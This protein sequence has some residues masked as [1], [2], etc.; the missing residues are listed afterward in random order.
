MA[1]LKRLK[2]NSAG[3]MAEMSFI[4]HLEELRGHLFRSVIAIVLGGI[5]VLR[6]IGIGEDRGVLGGIDVESGAD[7]QPGDLHGALRDALV[8]L[9]GRR[10]EKISALK[11]RACEARYPRPFGHSLKVRSQFAH[12]PGGRG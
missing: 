5:V 9:E 3:E 10:L 6:E 1:L 2:R 8:V 11:D 12:R 7:A 4:D